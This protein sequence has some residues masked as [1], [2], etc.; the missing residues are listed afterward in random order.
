MFLGFVLLSS[1]H[2]YLLLL[3]KEGRE[4]GKRKEEK[5]EM[6]IRE[7]GEG[8]KGKKGG[9][10]GEGG[11]KKDRSIPEKYVYTQAWLCSHRVPFSEQTTVRL[12]GRAQAMGACAI[13][14]KGDSC[15]LL[16]YHNVSS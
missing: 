4:K 5:E 1:K 14:A 8:K 10:E 13:Q 9:R 15:F 16:P 3:I 11:K 2:I 12:Q 7:K 6:R